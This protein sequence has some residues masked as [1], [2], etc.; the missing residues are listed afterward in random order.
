MQ[1]ISSMRKIKSKVAPN[2]VLNRALLDR[3]IT[4]LMEENARLRGAADQL[5]VERDDYSQ[6]L[7]TLTSQHNATAAR[8]DDLLREKSA[9]WWKGDP[10]KT[11]GF[12][13]YDIPIDLMLMTGGGPA[14]FD[15]VSSFHISTLKKW[16]GLDSSHTVLEIGCGIGRD[17]IPLTQILTDGRYVGIDIIK[18]SIDW[19]TGNIATRHSNFSFYHYDVEDELHNG[20][21]TTRTQDITVPMEDASVDRI[22]LFSVFTHLLQPEIEHYLREFRRV[23]KPGGL[24]YATTFI[25]DDAILTSARETALTPF[26]LRFEHEISPGCR[27]NDVAHP[28][29]AVA[30]KQAIW[31]SMVEKCGLR[32]VKPMLH[33]G[34]SG[35]YDD[36]ADGQDVALLSIA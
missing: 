15:E 28:L 12:M 21:G 8:L 7:D 13:G 18:R 9:A 17:A 14:S 11:H 30:Y 6:K 27:I 35:F 29:G 36:A 25:Y 10:T 16:I 33:G 19:C 22:F 2:L 20:G 3:Q 1:I 31:D 26:D 34:W 4:A 23:L 5:R 24:V 32:Y